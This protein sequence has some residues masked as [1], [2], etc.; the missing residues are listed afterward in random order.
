ESPLRDRNT[1]GLRTAADSGQPP[2]ELIFSDS[3]NTKWFLFKTHVIKRQGTNLKR[4]SLPGAL[5][6]FSRAGMVRMHEVFGTI[7]FSYGNIFMYY[8][9][10]DEAIVRL[11]TAPEDLSTITGLTSL[12]DS[13]LWITTLKQVYRLNSLHAAWQVVEVPEELTHQQYGSLFPY[14]IEAINE[15]LLFIS[16]MDSKLYRLEL[17]GNNIEFEKITIPKPDN[18]PLGVKNPIFD[19]IKLNDKTLLLGATLGMYEFDISTNQIKILT[20]EVINKL[21]YRVEPAANQI[22]SLSD[23]KLY[24]RA[25]DSENVYEI[26]AQ[27][28]I[29]LDNQN[30]YLKS[31]EVDKE[32]SIWISIQNQGVF[33]SSKYFNKFEQVH[34]DERPEW[35]E[36]LSHF[37]L[38]GS[39]FTI[40][41]ER[42]TLIST[43]GIE[44]QDMAYAV[45]PYQDN[46]YFL[47]NYGKVS[48]AS[49]DGILKVFD[50]P[51]SVVSYVTS[52]EFDHLGRLWAVSQLMGLYRYN[53]ET[54][55]LIDSSHISVSG[56][57]KTG[58]LTKF[59]Q[60]KLVLLSNLKVEIYQITDNGE[61][62]TAEFP[63]EGGLKLAERQHDHIL[64][65]HH[66][67]SI[68][69]F[70][71]ASRQLQKFTFEGVTN[72]GCAYNDGGA[73]WWLAQKGGRLYHLNKQT[74]QSTSFGHEDGLPF[75]GVSGDW[76]KE[77]KGELYFSTFKGFIKTTDKLHIE[78]TTPPSILINSVRGKNLD[79]KLSSLKLPLSLT[80]DNFP[81][82]FSFSNNSHIYPGDNQLS[83]FLRG[84]NTEWISMP[85][86]S[87]D[88]SYQ[89]LAP[90]DYTLLI[91]G[92]NNDGVW[93]DTA[94]QNFK[95]LPPLWLTWWAK[96]GYA[97]IF[98]LSLYILYRVRTKSIMAR[99]NF[100]EKTVKLRTSEI[101]QLLDQ[102]NEEFVNVS[103]EFRTPLT[104]ILGPVNRLIEKGSNDSKT[105]EIVK[106][107]G[108]RLLRLVDQLLHMERFSVPQMA[109]KVPVRIQPIAK[110]IGE[111]FQELAAERKIKLTIQQ[112]DDVW[113]EFTPDGLEKILLNLLSNALKYNR[114]GGEIILSVVGVN[115]NTIEI[116]VT[117]TGV[118][119]APEYQAEIFERFKRITDKQSEQVTGAGIG[120]ALVHSLV[121]SHGGEVQLESQK[122]QG[123]SFKILLNR[124]QP[125]QD[126]DVASIQTQAFDIEA[127]DLEIENLRE[128]PAEPAKDTAI[129]SR[130]NDNVPRILVVEDNR[131]MQEFLRECLAE[132]Y[133]VQVASNGLE[134]LTKATKDIPDLIV[135]DVMMPE[136]DGFQLCKEIKSQTITSHIPVL[137]LTAR[138]DRKSRIQGW[139]DQADEYLTKPFDQEELLIRIKN[140]LEIRELLKRRFHDQLL[141]Q[142]SN[143][144][145]KTEELSSTVD[146]WETQ[147]QIFVNKL[148]ELIEK[149]HQNSSL[150]VE[151]I[152]ENLAMSERQLY[153]KLKG[154]LNITP[155]ELLRSYRLEKAAQLINENHPVGNISFDVGFSSHSYFSQCFKAK[156]GMTP[157]EY[158][159]Q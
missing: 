123:S 54:R 135:S 14:D 34:L 5:S 45:T 9:Q 134:G 82:S 77:N 136:M 108:L 98:L 40:S 18:A 71:L 107:N 39:E 29:G 3:N 48:L 21:T 44:T 119:I 84:L 111:S 126:T 104:L 20:N 16:S 124:M 28:E 143:S 12:N 110:L 11:T 36:G 66:D 156:F 132:T 88:V 62:K 59:Q 7:L 6:D 159:K 25:P 120:L 101:Q 24:S 2:P 91:K 112:L 19:I 78:N 52:I 43:S 42:G 76:C 64:I 114:E 141:P 57:T 148:N 61:E 31:I 17:S 49:S 106:R 53:I 105:L 129:D 69:R 158:S 140:L 80:Q 128:Q 118:G 72:I 133:S 99:T 50:I 117:D 95:V 15:H 94:T 83:Y 8:S 115:D 152:A 75:G 33:Y 149:N 130:K 73:N 116:T 86:L 138:S 38:N 32:D 74:N 142:L 85:S 146:S 127:I 153:R 13:D 93:G 27:R 41:S 157:S 92:T 102:K 97:V 154:V 145:H 90:G 55:E 100:L 26:R 151:H 147:E 139:Q 137:L 122:G 37:E 109:N 125:D 51:N 10:E 4:Y 35:K 30:Y 60:D 70:D 89:T 79:I 81:V 58:F 56:P 23:D 113:V 144:K 67:E 103:H 68:S 150:K 96:L 155:A 47:G 121:T 1:A 63:F 131:D 22:W 87:E 46:T 65:Y